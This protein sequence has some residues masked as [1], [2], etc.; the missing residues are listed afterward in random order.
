MNHQQLVVRSCGIT[1]ESN[2]HSSTAAA[3]NAAL[4][5][6]DNLAKRVYGGKQ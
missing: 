2:S 3:A 1:S 5:K 6:F 4:K